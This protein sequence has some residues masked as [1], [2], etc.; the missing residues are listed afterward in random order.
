MSKIKKK[1]KKIDKRKT[2]FSIQ[3]PSAVSGFSAFIQTK[4]LSVSWF[5]VCTEM[6]LV[7]SNHS[8]PDL[9]GSSLSTVHQ[10]VQALLPLP[11]SPPQE[12]GSGTWL[13]SHLCVN[14]HSVLFER[15]FALICHSSSECSSKHTSSCPKP[16]YTSN[17]GHSCKLGLI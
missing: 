6:F 12:T 9:R 4:L 8:T 13:Y 5:P 7:R 2:V 3:L 10:P 16:F 15:C 14:P 11:V 1:K 17:A